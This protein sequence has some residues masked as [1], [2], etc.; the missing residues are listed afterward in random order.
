MRRRRRR[1]SADRQLRDER[2]AA[3][4]IV[5]AA[6]RNKKEHAN[7]LGRA[8]AHSLT[9]LGPASITHSRGPVPSAVGKSIT[10][11]F[12]VIEIAAESGRF[13]KGSKVLTPNC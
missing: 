1:R 6:L 13:Y 4:P 3:E 12:I 5:T 7:Y 8:T 10:P 2:G 9:I 11:R